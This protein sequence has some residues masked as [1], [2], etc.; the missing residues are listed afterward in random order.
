MASG[1][2]RSMR[3]PRK[4]IEPSVTSPSSDFSKPEM[5]FSMVVL[6]APFGPSKA[7]ICRSRTTREMP[8]STRMAR[9]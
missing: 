8:L 7:T 5:A 6:P 1:S 2:I 9:S 4:R 3:R